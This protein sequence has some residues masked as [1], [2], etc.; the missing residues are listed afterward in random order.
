M[1]DN[2]RLFLLVALAL[3]MLLI[4]TNWQQD[5]GPRA[6]AITQSQSQSGEAPTASTPARPAA[7]GVDDSGVE[8]S[9]GRDPQAST[10]ETAQRVDS[11]IDTVRVTTDVF[12]IEI[13]LVGGN[14]RRADL[15]KHTVAV[16][17]PTPFTL[18]GNA[19]PLFVAQSGLVGDDV[20]AP[21]HLARW[22][23]ESERYTL[24]DGQQT[25][26][27]PLT[28]QNDA[29]VTVTRRY[30]F[31]RDSY[32]VRV[33]HEV[34]NASTIDWRAYQYSQLRRTTDAEG[35]GFL[36]AASYTGGVIYSPADKYQKIS[37][38]DMD[39]EN[40]SRDIADG[41]LAM[42]Q[43]YFLAAWVPNR[44]QSLR[45]YTRVSGGEYILGQSSPWQT[46]AAG[47]QAQFENQLFV[48]PKV[49]ERLAT[50]AEG[51]ELT[52][53][54]GWLTI[55]SKPLFIA[56]SWIHDVVGNWGWSIILLTF[57]IKLIFYKLSETSYRSMARMRKLQPEMKKLRERHG[58]DRQ[59]MNQELM[60]LYKKEKVNP[61]GGCLPI[62][63]QIPVFIALYWALLESVELRQ[64]PW[65]LWIQDLSVRDPYY[66]L[67]LIMGV[68]M[69]LQQKLNPAPMDPIQQKI[70]MGLP[71]VFTVFFVFFPAG[72][73]LYWVTNNSL[74]IL[75]QWIITR[76]IEAGGKK[77][78]A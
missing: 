68:T 16:D 5:Y 28:W 77:A 9:N 78:D 3:V 4:W 60:Q 29:G 48:G 35:P 71:V 1:M 25:L 51:L 57:G 50:V 13:P 75:Q 61:L 26:E 7:P 55:I 30:I 39:D 19:D 33:I 45:Y 17:D 40:L 38:G 22:Q 21:D 73:V 59:Q 6:P 54:Y 8:R 34:D 52:V 20:L 37:F 14:I 41:W 24:E 53:D 44:E 23:V 27:V 43:H 46:V 12:A 11:T 49:Q 69:F 63:I 66:V 58:D 2:Q 65:I 56:L 18:L 15:L 36:G 64:A 72:L 62:L 47:S 32:L 70:M 31:S 10:A 76:R 67:P 42:I 74:S